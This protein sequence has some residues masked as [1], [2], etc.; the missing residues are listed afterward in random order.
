MQAR[1]G[2]GTVIL[3]AALAA[4]AG[5]VVGRT[6]SGNRA[7]DAAAVRAHIESIFQAFIDKDRAK[8]AA[9]HGVNWRGFQAGSSRVIRGR[10]GY[11]EASVGTGPLPPK[12]QGMVGYRIS[13][14]DTVFYGDAAVST[15]VAEVDFVDG[16]RRGTSKLNLLDVHA[17]EDGKWIQ[18]AS[19]TSYHPEY[20]DTLRS[21]FGL[22]SDEQKTAILTAREKVWRAWYSGDVAQFRKLVPAELI[23]LHPGSASFGTYDSV[24]A[25]SKGFAA[26]G[27]KLARLVFPKTE[28]Q[29]YGNTVIIY[30]SYELDV[31]RGGKTETEKGKATEIFVRRKGDWL[32]T[33]WQLAP[34][35]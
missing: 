22:P 27:G 25:A 10:E 7:Q 6:Q 3:V 31:E 13:D 5:V 18:V 14:F 33:G 2:L 34:E 35:R 4:S 23:T 15:F 21:A 8:L 19:N 26:S 11:M 16:E 9:T 28:F 32:N 12:G 24:I 30:T 17:R 1:I 20:Q 29:Q